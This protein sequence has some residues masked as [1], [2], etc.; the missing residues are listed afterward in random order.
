[1]EPTIEETQSNIS[2]TTKDFQ[3]VF[4]KSIWALWT[5][6]TIWTLCILLCNEPIQI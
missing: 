3:T 6:W 5:L 1:M 4:N 2:K